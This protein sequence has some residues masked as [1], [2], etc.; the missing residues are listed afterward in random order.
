MQVVQIKDI[1]FEDLLNGVYK[2]E[3]K[4]NELNSK[5]SANKIELV[6]MNKALEVLGISRKTADNWHKQGILN[7]KYIGG[8]VYYS[9]KEIEKRMED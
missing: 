6:P 7:K 4:I 9:I 8:K 3:K 1:E 5:L 2:L